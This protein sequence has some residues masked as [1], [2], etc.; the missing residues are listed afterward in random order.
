MLCHT[1]PD[2]A[3]V[4]LW[5]LI[6]G[7]KKEKRKKFNVKQ[8]RVMCGRKEI[9]GERDLGGRKGARRGRRAEKKGRAG[10]GE[11]MK[12]RTKEKLK[13]IELKNRRRERRRTARERQRKVRKGK[14]GRGRR[15][16]S[17]GGREGAEEGEGDRCDPP[18]LGCLFSQ[19]RQ[20]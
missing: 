10:G 11:L 4:F 12:E 1:S 2:D 3:F 5:L 20:R 7:G 13:L 14:R 16:R 8:Q 6:L 18:Q 19:E 9:R 15:G 17:G